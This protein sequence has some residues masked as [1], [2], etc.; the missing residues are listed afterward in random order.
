MAT[1]GSGSINDSSTDYELIQ[2]R[3]GRLERGY[4]IRE[5]KPTH[6]KKPPQHLPHNPPQKNHLSNSRQ[7]KYRLSVSRSRNYAELHGKRQSESEYAIPTTQAY[8]I[9]RDTEDRHSHKY[10][11][12]FQGSVDESIVED[13]NVECSR[14]LTR[15]PQEAKSHRRCKCGCI[16]SILLFVTLIITLLVALTALGLGLYGMFVGHNSSSHDAYTH[17]WCNVT[18]TRA[19]F[20]VNCTQ[21]S[22]SCTTETLATNITVSLD[23]TCI[24]PYTM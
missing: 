12:F 6:L 11:A 5:A 24:I 4:S 8:T 9:T 18:M 7:R 21:Y 22:V 10:D 1:R 16:K 2:P 19:A 17:T 13:E 3:D 20:A 23:D 14:S 15:K